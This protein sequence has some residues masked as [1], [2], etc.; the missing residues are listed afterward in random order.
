MGIS[1]CRN[2]NELPVNRAKVWDIYSYPT[3]NWTFFGT[4]RGVVAHDG[5]SWVFCSLNNESEI[6]CVTADLAKNRLLVSGI[7]EFGYMV[8]D[9][10][11]SFKYT[12]LSEGVGDLKFIGNIWN[13]L[14]SEE[15]YIFQG[16]RHLLFYN[17]DIP[18]NSSLITSP[19]KINCSAIVNNLLYLGTEHGVKILEGDKLIN[20]SGAEQL[21]DFRIRGILN[22]NEGLLIVTA[23]EGVY[24]YSYGFI[25]KIPYSD[26]FGEIFSCAINGDLLALGSISHGVLIANLMTGETI[27]YDEQNGLSSNTVLSLEFDNNSNLWIGHDGGLEQLFIK[28]PFRTLSNSKLPIGYGYVSKIINNKLYIGTNRGLYFLS[29][30]IR[31]PLDFNDLQTIEGQVWNLREIG[32]KLYLCH[33][34]GLYEL[35]ERRV[36]KIEGLYGVWDIQVFKKDPDYALVGT[37]DGLF[38]M[39][40]NSGSK[41]FR[42]VSKIEGYSGSPYNFSQEGDSIIWIC[43]GTDGIIRLLLDD[44]KK[45][46]DTQRFTNADDGTPLVGNLK[47]GGDDN[48][49]LFLTDNGIY[50]YDKSKKSIVRETN[51]NKLIN[52][53]NKC[54]T[55]K[56]HGE[57]IYAVTDHEL[58]KIDLSTGEHNVLPLSN[59]WMISRHYGDMI[60]IV[61]E[62]N[63]I[64]P[65][66]K[67]LT[68]VTFGKEKF[69]LNGLSINP[70]KINALYSTNQ[71]DSLL[72]QSNYL[73]VRENVVLDF[74]HNSVRFLFGNDLLSNENLIQYRFRLNDEPW[75]EPS[76]TTI[77]EFT[78]LKEGHYNFVV[79][80]LYNDN[81][82]AEDSMDFDIRPP[83]Y[84]QKWAII[85]Y[86]LLLLAIGTLI[87]YF[88][89]LNFKKRQQKIIQRGEEELLHQRQ[90]FEEEER[91]KNEQ[92]AL[93]EREKLQDEFNRKTQEI[94]NL[95]ISEANKNEILIDLK[96]GLKSIMKSPS[97]T[98][99]NRRAIALLQDKINI[100]L[101]GAKVLKRA[102]D[103][104]NVLYNNFTYRLREEFPSLSNGEVMLCS[105]LKMNLTSKEIA[106]LMRVSIRGIETMRYRLRK[107]MGLKREESLSSFIANFN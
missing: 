82:V 53:P 55:L 98:A 69:E 33:D 35:D 101:D 12:C 91:K 41:S 17:E 73:N 78:D 104:F 27:K 99:D 2:L 68:F 45:I 81:V 105:Y 13:I 18:E 57:I 32:G 61:D 20:L 16:D 100:G 62:N 44:E 11:G 6:R 79:Q 103:E 95:L 49:P 56:K 14:D 28:F 97:M 9:H 3:D 70:G 52:S 107:K 93:L 89:C 59:E 83:W 22:G 24:S 46:V 72:Y 21:N 25:K 54:V 65:S 15:G 1:L 36:T 8:P 86:N 63:L 96:E 85:T 102:E 88:I 40:I 106:P 64:L 58:I 76:F 74:D 60:E 30:P 66:M 67:G 4:N 10:N 39:G 43:E 31:Y 26:D 50:L 38:L 92:I 48:N 71:G 37:Y 5:N 90:E 51:I 34:R 7:N 77:K 42:K 87:F 29:L 47:T 94:S 23:T 80:S 84:R 19:D 75:S